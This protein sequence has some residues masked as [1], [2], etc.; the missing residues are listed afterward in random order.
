MSKNPEVWTAQPATQ[1]SLLITHHYFLSPFSQRIEIIALFLKQALFYQ[2]LNRV[3][4]RGARVRIVLAGLKEG[5]QVKL[6]SFPE[7]KTSQNA[8]VDFIHG[9]IKGQVPG[10][11]CFCFIFATIDLTSGGTARPLASSSG[12]EG[13]SAREPQSSAAALRALRF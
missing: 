6:L 5:V 9:R 3:E 10:Y 7:F 12:A 2:T 13:G 11:G 1:Y 4:N 8:L